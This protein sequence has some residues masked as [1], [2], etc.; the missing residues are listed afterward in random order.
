[1]SSAKCRPFCLG[2]NV[3]KSVELVCWPPASLLLTWTELI[4]IPQGKTHK[5]CEE[6]TYHLS[7][8]KLQVQPWKFGNGYVNTKQSPGSTRPGVKYV[9]E[10]DS[11]QVAYLNYTEM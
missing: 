4:L 6:I 10:I 1:M 5:D 3:L 8:P 2:F 9:F 7:I 11:F